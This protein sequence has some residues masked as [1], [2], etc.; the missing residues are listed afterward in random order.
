MSGFLGTRAPLFPDVVVVALVVV[1]PLFLIGVSLAKRKRLRAH[2]AVMQATFGVLAVVV[3]AFVVW[4]RLFAPGAP[5][6]EGTWLHGAVYRPLIFLHI[7]VALSSLALGASTILRA[8][9]RV[10]SPERPAEVKL[11][12]G[13]RGRHHLEGYATLS[14]LILTSG[15]GLAIYYLRYIWVG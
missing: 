12:E 10:I 1:I 2:L 4:A 15:S 9:R 6:L 5:H 3:V 7:V 14:A 8:R 11:P 13:Y